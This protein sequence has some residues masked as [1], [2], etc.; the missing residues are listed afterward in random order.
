[1]HNITWVFVCF[2]VVFIGTVKSSNNFAQDKLNKEVASFVL[3]LFSS[4]PP[5]FSDVLNNAGLF[6][7]LLNEAERW[8]V[9]IKRLHVD[10]LVCWKCHKDTGH[11]KQ[12]FAL[13]PPASI[14]D[15][16]FL[17]LDT[18]FQS[19]ISLQNKRNK[20]WSICRRTTQNLHQ[21]CSGFPSGG[22]HHFSLAY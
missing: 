10:Q 8:N 20:L 9:Q 13:L 12:S 18:L 21:C 5:S 19:I 15:C 7:L 2:F 11:E 1:M 3:F 16:I 22:L 14:L 4:P 17:I 6:L